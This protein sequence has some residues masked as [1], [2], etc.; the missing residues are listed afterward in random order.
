MFSAEIGMKSIWIYDVYD[1]LMYV[2]VQV[3]SSPIIEGVEGVLLTSVKKQ[4]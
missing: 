2:N 3:F 4:E 1:V